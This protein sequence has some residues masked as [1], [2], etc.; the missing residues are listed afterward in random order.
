MER[1]TNSSVRVAPLTYV[2]PDSGTPAAEGKPD[3]YNSYLNRL[4][5]ALRNVRAT[6]GDGNE[7]DIA[8]AIER[9]CNWAREKGRLNHNVF[10]IGNGA[11]AT[12]ASHMAVDS[13]KGLG[14]RAM[15][16]NDA[17]LMSAIGNDIGYESTFE[18]PLRWFG[19]ADDLLITVSSSG[20]SPNIVKALACA[21][22][23]KMQIV[24]LSGM[25]PENKSRRG[26]GLN[27]YVPDSTYGI[28]ESAHAAIL[29]CWID[30]T[31]A[32]F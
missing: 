20:N 32:L 13:A 9:W 15:A 19:K 3:R 24:T 29:H 28:V 8:T 16:F 12:M 4:D 1:L 7:L 25:T 21:N 26:G 17:A 30:E 2:A 31:K 23:M 22:T 11:S 18:L 14:L 10:I 5:H 6:D 27:F